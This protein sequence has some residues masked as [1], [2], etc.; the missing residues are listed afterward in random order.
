M[1]V[2]IDGPAGSGKSTVAACLADRL[3]IGYLDTGAMYRAVTLAALKKNV[4]LTQPEKLAKLAKDCRIEFHTKD[5]GTE[6]RLDGQ[7]VT[8]EI[9]L[10]EV[11]DNAHYIA[12]APQVREVLVEQQQ[13]IAR[14]M[15]ALVTEG[16]D[17]GTVVFPYAAF[18]FYLD[19]SPECRAQRRVQQLQQKGVAARYDEILAAQNERDQRDSS[20]SVG[21]LKPAPD[22]I[23]VDTTNLTIDEVIENL[24]KHIVTVW[25]EAMTESKT[26]RRDAR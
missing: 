15:G 20:R 25:P 10:P 17:Q 16:R 26:D 12:G 19:A 21:P 11:S 18:K 2:T 6:V 22:A 9:R 24:Y 3:Q 7:D 14:E 8:D 13:R 4:E 23:R 1:I 5:L